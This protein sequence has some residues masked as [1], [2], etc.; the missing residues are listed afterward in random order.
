MKHLLI[1]AKIVIF[2]GE[3]SS[4]TF[5]N[6]AAGQMKKT[7]FFILL[8]G[9]LLLVLFQHCKKTADEWAFCAGCGL[10]AWVGDY[11]GTGSYY[12]DVGKEITDG[13]DVQL[14]ITNPSGNQFFIKVLSPDYYSQSFFSSKNDSNYF[15]GI[16]SESSSI[17][18][19][20]Y[21]KGDEFKVSG[22]AKKYHWEWQYEPD[23]AYVL[24]PDHTLS[25]EVFKGE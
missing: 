15:F 7:T 3:F 6:F 16:E 23:T 24:I 14:E 21:K 13:V 17:Q 10:D 5:F 9:F 2:K 18:I 20:L 1:A 12:K 25:F 4:D 11:T 22:V 8:S 19:N